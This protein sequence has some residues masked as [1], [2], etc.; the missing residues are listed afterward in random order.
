M[1]WLNLSVQDIL[2]VSLELSCIDKLLSA[3][4]EELHQLFYM[5]GLALD[6]QKKT[7]GDYLI[8]L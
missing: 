3:H 4:L 5:L 8:D 1:V 2:D 7:L 6:V